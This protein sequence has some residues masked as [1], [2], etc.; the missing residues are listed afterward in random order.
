MIVLEIIFVIVIIAA[1]V[2]VV[3]Q[4][5]DLF[6]KAN[7]Y[8]AY[9]PYERFFKRFLDA[10]L[11]TGAVIVLSPVFL[12]LTILGGIEMKGNPFFTQE[13]PGLNGNIFKLIKFRTMSNAKDKDGKLL[14]DEKRINRYGRVLRSTSLDELPELLNIIW[15]DMSIIG[16][17]P[18]ISAYLPYYTKEEKHRHDVRPGLTGLA[19]VNGRSFISWED[20]FRYDVD[21][22]KQVTFNNDLKIILLTIKKVIKR[23]DIADL[24]ESYAGEDGKKHFIVDG[25]D[26]T[27]HQPL[28]VERASKNVARDRQ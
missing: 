26:V 24:T 8:Q 19:Q 17:R 5:M 7:G 15:G 14:P 10:F 2:G 21:Y 27:L 12:A 4:L 1:C 11:S 9:G 18:L 20:I 6:T 22:A 13:R 16:P 23:K 28:N 25:K 3:A